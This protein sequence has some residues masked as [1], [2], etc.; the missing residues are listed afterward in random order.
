MSVSSRKDVREM[1]FYNVRNVANEKE[2][3]K[4]KNKDI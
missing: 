4:Q 2:E 3:K 1:A